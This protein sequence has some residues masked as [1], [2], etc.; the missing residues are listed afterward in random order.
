MKI[1]LFTEGK[2]SLPCRSCSEHKDISLQKIKS[3]AN[4]IGS[5]LK[6]K[7][8]N[9]TIVICDNNYI[10]KINKVYRKK[11]KPTDVIAFAYRENPF[12]DIKGGP[13]T[14]GDIYIS[15][16][17]ASENAKA[18]ETSLS[19]E[20]RRLLAHGILHLI[21]YD[22]ERSKKDK[23]IMEEKEEEIFNYV[24]SAHRRPALRKPSKVF[25]KSS[26]V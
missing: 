22:H 9:L 12:P 10:L 14:L 11:N 25:H 17:K 3:Y 21:G 19:E 5:F 13:E 8:I 16:E 1:D 26:S 6:L 4:K 20:L 23:K 2:I 18:Y 7:N 15:L 24:S